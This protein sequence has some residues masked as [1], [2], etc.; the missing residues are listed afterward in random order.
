MSNA[1]RLL[2]PY[3]EDCNIDETYIKEVETVYEHLTDETSK[4]IYQSRIM[5][6]LTGNVA[7]MRDLIL[8]V[9]QNRELHTKLSNQKV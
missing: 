4:I 1:Y 9:P 3:E 5:S 8:S 6:A 2:F 7:C